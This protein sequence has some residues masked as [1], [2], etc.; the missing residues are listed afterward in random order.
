[1]NKTLWSLLALSVFTTASLTAQ[2]TKSSNKKGD[3]KE[4]VIEEKSSGKNEKM[5]IVIDGDNITINGKPADSYKGN[6]RIIIDDDI[7]INGDE[8]HIPRKGRMYMRGFENDNHAMLGVVTDKTDN[9]VKVKEVMKS[10]AAEKAGLKEG[11]VITSVNGKTIKAHEDLVETIDK[12]KPN[13]VADVTYLRSGKENKVKATLG[14]SQAP[15]AMTWNMDNKNHNYQFR[16]E[17]PMAMVT[18]RPGKPFVFNDG[19]MWMFRN[20]KPR[21]GM[22]IEDNAD[23]DGVKITAVDS[24]SN[25]MKAGIKENDIITEL[26]G[27]PIKGTDELKEA[28]DDVEDKSSISVKVLRNGAPQ[29]I[30]LRVPK[31]IK[32]A[33]L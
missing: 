14:K 1:M 9:G 6:K 26:E 12:L 8:V 21:Y 13:D 28:L 33:D 22:S 2:D 24:G 30:T 27:K 18:P 17:P 23:G 10:S 3:K 25:A 15:R 29:S 7:S 32:K 5:V 4:I 11:D 19:D 20:D 16:M 31:L